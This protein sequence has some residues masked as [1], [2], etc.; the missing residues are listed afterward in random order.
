MDSRKERTAM[1]SDFEN[2]E[3]KFKKVRVVAWLDEKEAGGK[4]VAREKER[5]G[6]ARTEKLPAPF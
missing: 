3:R 4:A 1:V 2:F 5:Q 6:L